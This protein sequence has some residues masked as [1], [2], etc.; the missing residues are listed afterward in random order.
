MTDPI[1][2]ATLRLRRLE[3]A[4]DVAP[5]FPRDALPSAD[6]PD[7]L[8][9]TAVIPQ[10]LINHRQVIR[11]GCYHAG[12]PR[13]E[14]RKLKLRFSN[15]RPTCL[16]IACYA[17]H[18]RPLPAPTIQIGATCLSGNE[19][20]RV[21]GEGDSSQDAARR[22]HNPTAGPTEPPRREVRRSGPGVATLRSLRASAVQ[23]QQPKSSQNEA[24]F[25]DSTAKTRRHKRFGICC[26]RPCA[27]PFGKPNPPSHHTVFAQ[28][29]LRLC[30]SALSFDSLLT[31]ANSQTQQP[32]P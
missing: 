15:L 6:W 30:A 10:T 1:P 9:R 24:T 13:F 20:I 19:W 27:S 2:L 23:G 11:S 25:T 7:A 4:L 18:V 29:S 26:H 14:N 21:H 17:E 8:R 22:S 32:Q 12:T 31:A 28:L 3:I 16:Q 5:V